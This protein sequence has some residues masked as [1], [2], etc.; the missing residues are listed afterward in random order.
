MAVA[1][2]SRFPIPNT[3]FVVVFN[4]G[5]FALG[6]VTMWLY[7]SMRSF[8]GPGPKTAA[9]AGLAVWFCLSVADIFWAELRFMPRRLVG[10]SIA[11]YLVAIVAA[12]MA[13]A[14]QYRDAAGADSLRGGG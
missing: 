7:A 12:T 13:G 11:V 8:H 10:E 9:M 14:W 4:V 6:V 5:V 1:G 3:E 2:I